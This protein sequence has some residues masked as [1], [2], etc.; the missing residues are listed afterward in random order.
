MKERGISGRAIPIDC[1]LV[2]PRADWRDGGNVS[3]MG[4]GINSLLSRGSV[5]YGPVGIVECKR[6][7]ENELN[8]PSSKQL[9]PKTTNEKSVYKT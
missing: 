9:L 6:R 3:G 1:D 5:F 4:L 2:C 8:H 7:G